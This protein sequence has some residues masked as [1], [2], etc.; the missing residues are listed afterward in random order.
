MVIKDARLIC[1]SAV[2]SGL[3]C[4]MIITVF[5][6]KSSKL[7]SK[8]YSRMMSSAIQVKTK[9]LYIYSYLRLFM[10]GPV[11]MYMGLTILYPS[12][13][14]TLQCISTLL[15]GFA[16]FTNVLVYF[17]QRRRFAMSGRISMECFPILHGQ[18]CNN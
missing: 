4:L 15:L 5:Y 14:S 18:C 17:V 12:Y 8:M 11:I 10:F 2:F 3:I 6:C 9:D 1:M 13:S 7:V 16:G